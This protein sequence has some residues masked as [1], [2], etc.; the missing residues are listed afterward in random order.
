[1]HAF[2]LFLINEVIASVVCIITVTM[3]NLQYTFS[4]GVSLLQNPFYPLKNFWWK[5]ISLASHDDAKI[6]GIFNS[7]DL[8]N[9]FKSVGHQ[10][11]SFNTSETT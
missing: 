9:L 5:K 4:G 11:R 7:I 2:D 6:K 3:Q 1:M 10:P 8:K